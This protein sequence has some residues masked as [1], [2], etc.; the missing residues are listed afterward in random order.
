MIDV[1]L[2]LQQ[3]IELAQQAHDV[4]KMLY[5]RWNDLYNND[6]LKSCVGWKSFLFI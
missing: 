2:V 3:V 1:L 5:G 4:R 6:F